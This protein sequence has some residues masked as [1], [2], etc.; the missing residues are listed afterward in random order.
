MNEADTRAEK[1]DPKLKNS[2]WGI[3]EGTK[4]RREYFTNQDSPFRSKRQ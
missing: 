4:I 2:G 3:I 1:I